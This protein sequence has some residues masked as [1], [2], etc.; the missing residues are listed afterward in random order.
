M[1]LRC[2]IPLQRVAVVIFFAT[3]MLS[4]VTT[5][6]SVIVGG[7]TRTPISPN[8]VRIFINPPTQYEAIA[9]IEA[10]REMASSRQSTQDRLTD[11]LKIRAAR[12][13]ANGV[14]I[15]STDTQQK[16]GLWTTTHLMS[17][18]RAIFVIQE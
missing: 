9:I 16:P 13:G 14:I 15:L 5:Q 4:C 17:Q 12:L 3:L 6:S 1:K 8:E 7:Q 18:G 10:S 11:E 2:I